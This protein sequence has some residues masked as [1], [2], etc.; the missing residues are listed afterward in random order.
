MPTYKLDP[1][2]VGEYLALSPADKAAFRRAKDRFVMALKAGRRLDV[3]LD[4]HQLTDHPGIYEF[5]FSRRGRA[6]F[7]YGSAERGAAAHVI[8]RHIGGHEI[9]QEP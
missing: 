8:W 7:R 4:V 9:Y 3:G 2:F 6:T 5:R 1:D